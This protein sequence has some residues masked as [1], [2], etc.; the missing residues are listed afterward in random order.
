M[1]ELFLAIVM[2]SQVT[3]KNT[4]DGFKFA[5]NAECM[6]YKNNR[7]YIDSEMLKFTCEKSRKG[8]K[9]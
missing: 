6:A 2:N 5:T 7:N 3:A 9:K 1:F 4:I 8:V